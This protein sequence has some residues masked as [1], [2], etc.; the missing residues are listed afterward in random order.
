MDGWGLVVWMGG[1]MGRWIFVAQIIVGRIVFV[2]ILCTFS[3]FSMSSFR[4]GFHTWM[5]Y[6]NRCGLTSDLYDLN[7]VSMS[8]VTNVLLIIPK[9]VS[10]FDASAHCL[11]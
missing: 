7:I 3:S 6:S 4:Y 5:Q 11:E 2:S 9:V 1:W 8:L 10:L